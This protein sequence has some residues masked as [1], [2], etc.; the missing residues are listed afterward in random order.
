MRTL[1]VSLVV[2]SI[3]TGCQPKEPTE[4]DTQ[5]QAITA[6]ALQLKNNM[7]NPDSFKLESALLIAGADA[8]CFTYRAQNGFGGMNRGHAVLTGAR[9][10]PKLS[11]REVFANVQLKTS[12]EPGFTR[13][14]NKECA[15]KSG[16]EKVSLVTIAMGL[17]G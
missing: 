7:R 12:E 9:F 15:G 13:L 3:L 6:V 4:R 10:D 8:V 16:E 1:I 2:T 17:A 5:L 14:W 11:G